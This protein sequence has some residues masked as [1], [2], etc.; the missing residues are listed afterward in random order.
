MLALERLR[1]DEQSLCTLDAGP[2]VLIEGSASLPAITVE[3]FS[4][5]EAV[6][7]VPCGRQ[8]D[9]LAVPGIMIGPTRRPAGIAPTRRPVKAP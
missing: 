6:H 9:T 8:R 2:R 1:Q 3:D 4:V 7:L 5:V